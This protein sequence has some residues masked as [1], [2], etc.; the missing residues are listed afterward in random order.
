MARIEIHAWYRQYR[1]L[2]DQAAD[3]ILLFRFGDFYETFDDDAKLIAELL[4]VTLTRKDYA[5][6]KSKPRD[7]QKLYAPMAGMPYHAVE[8]YVTDLVGRGYRV[9]IAE[10]M[11]ETEASRNDTRPRSVFASGLQQ[12]TPTEHGSKMVHREIVRVITPGTVVDSSMLAATTNN[13]LAAALV[14]GEAIGLAYADLSTG[15]FAAVE[16]YGERS[17]AQLHGE[18]SRLQAAEV[19]VPDLENLRLPEFAPSQSRLT[20]DLAP[21]TKDERDMLLPHERVARRLDQA[22]EARWTQGHV[23]AWAAWRWDLREATEVLLRQLR[24]SSLAAFGLDAHPL[25]TRAAGALLQ[26]VHETQRHHAAQLNTLRVYATGSFMLLDP[27]TRRNL[28]LLEPQ[29]QGAK[30]AL[31]SVLDR[32]RTPMG[33]RL[34]RR[35]LNQPLLELEPLLARQ[36]AVARLVEETVLRATLRE[37]LGPVGDMERAL[38]RIAQGNSV[39]TPRDLVQLRSSLR[40]LP[41]VLAAVGVVLAELLPAEA[42]HNDAVAAAPSRETDEDLFGDAEDAVVA[43]QPLLDPCGDLLALLE[44]GLDDDPPA[45]LGAS[46]YLRAA[47]EGGE[48]P[49][50]VIRPGFD[51]RMDALVQA[52]RHAQEFIDR[53]EG[54]E[55]ERTGIKA[56]KVGYNNVFG[57]YIELSRNVDERLIPKDY[58]RKQTLVSAER[59]IT[60]ELK[61][62]EQ[63]IDRARLQL[64][65]L[66]RDAF[67]RLCEALSKGIERLRR[68]ARAL[69]HLDAMASLAEAAVRGRYAR[70]NLEASTR[71]QITAG[72]H[73]VVE[74]VLEDAFVPNDLRLDTDE[75]QLLIITGPNMAGKCVVGA[76]LVFS[77]HG[78]VRI[79]DL[80]PSEAVE[81][82]FAPLGRVV[83]GLEQPRE[84][85]HFY[86]GG[87]Q[88]T[89]RLTT[90]HGF[91]LEGT[92]EH[93][94]RVRQPDGH[95]VW[96]C[97]GDLQPGDRVALVCGVNLWGRDPTIAPAQ[98]YQLGHDL[99]SRG[100]ILSVTGGR[101][102]KFGDTSRPG[103]AGVPPAGAPEAGGTP[104][105]PGMPANIVDRLRNASQVD[106]TLPTAAD[107][108]LAQAHPERACC[109]ATSS[110]DCVCTLPTA[111]LG[112]PRETIVAFLQ[113]L[114]ASKFASFQPSG[115]LQWL[116]PSTAIAQQV[117]LLLLNLG[118]IATVE[119][120]MVGL[121][122]DAL[123][124]DVLLHPKRS[125]RMPKQRPFDDPVVS[126]T[127]GEAE[128]YDLSVDHD[129]AYLANG[130]VSH[131]STCLRQVA[132]I[133]LMAQIGSF[134]PAEAATIGLVDR[135]FTR[136]G[137]QD[138]IA[139]GQSTFM[140]EMTETAALLLQSTRRSLIILDE[141]GRGTSTY[142]GMAIARAVVE[143]IHNE[144]RLRCRTLFAT[145]YH[146]LTALEAVLPRLRNYHMAAVEKEGQVVFL[147]ELRRGGADRSYGIHVA[148]LAGIPQ[149]VIARASALLRELEGERSKQLGKESGEPLAPGEAGTEQ[150][151]PDPAEGVALPSRGRRDDATMPRSPADHGDSAE[152]GDERAAHDETAAAPRARH[153]PR[154]VA[155]ETLVEPAP[156]ALNAP[157]F[158]GQLSLFDLAPSPVIAYLRRL[159]INELTPLDAL[160]RLAEL[161][162]LAGDEHR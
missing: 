30:T 103:C 156:V 44:A 84:A 99:G 162:R 43:Q 73:P 21:M 11:T 158:E 130:L 132:L 64:T 141:V 159:N 129:H 124:N 37:A 40:A 96:R 59:Y 143:Y 125:L 6:D 89:I 87:R 149:A 52:S 122:L 137:A 17:A 9:A 109:T 61:E 72:R 57:Y 20:Q 31:I 7:Q 41:A 48:R 45:L 118:L 78:L 55:R 50:R 3:A 104:A 133:V 39:A 150:T 82:A 74:Q 49:R 121:P 18:L 25:A 77:E 92:P 70:P 108:S 138:D 98:A 106:K 1:K 4:D 83:Q 80:M 102:V 97:L 16:F 53:L 144:P 32:T 154:P 75:A 51:P 8:R 66:E 95:E 60:A 15:E 126:L 128:V 28:E 160:N 90:Q 88:A 26:Y 13:Y 148:Q 46:N 22:S 62:Y 79:A 155:A 127:P 111:L 107:D 136:I 56:L 47:E 67:G 140:V 93:R 142:D 33:A 131:N 110:A 27:Q 81:G 10:Q 65:D 153:T 14:E 100:K 19:L 161:Q 85:T 134:V 63:I 35:W 145:H 58:E 12:T 139:T 157:P 105:Y 94:V 5:V 76:T 54:K 119:G 36:A 112:A 91:T 152:P 2:K 146:E 24:V 147:H 69:A 42:A 68:A 116:M 113:G 117:Q 135:I 86:C 71:L 101:C 23:T 115:I 151:P 38:N 29:R 114:C 34:L 120:T 123:P